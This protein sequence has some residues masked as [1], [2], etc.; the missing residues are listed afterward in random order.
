V[1][2]WCAEPRGLG[3]APR[4]PQRGSLV[5]RRARLP[6]SFVACSAPRADFVVRQRTATTCMAPM[7][8]SPTTRIRATQLAW[9]ASTP[10]SAVRPVSPL[11]LL[12]LLSAHLNLHVASPCSPHLRQGVRQRSRRLWRHPVAPR[13]DS[14]LLLPVRVPLFQRVPRISLHVDLLRNH[15]LVDAVLP[16]PRESSLRSRLW[17][18][19][20]CA[21]RSAR[22]RPGP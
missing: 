11:L 20:R 22:I 2:A 4:L 8:R 16:P 7:R 12:S 14:H 6:C 5:V 3:D 21:I 13:R 19:S 1:D 17:V 10:F 15:V 9:S 18:A